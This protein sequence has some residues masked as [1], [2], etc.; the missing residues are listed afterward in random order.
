MG[1]YN[2]NDITI[3]WATDLSKLGLTGTDGSTHGG[4][5]M[6]DSTYNSNFYL[7]WQSVANKLNFCSNAINVTSST[8]PYISIGTNFS[9]IEKQYSTITVPTGH[10]YV[11]ANDFSSLKYYTTNINTTIDIV[12]AIIDPF[13]DDVIISG[14]YGRNY[15][16]TD[17]A[18]R[19]DAAGIYKSNLSTTLNGTTTTI[20]AFTRTINGSNNFGTAYGRLYHNSSDTSNKYFVEYYASQSSQPSYRRHN[21]TSYTDSTWHLH[22]VYNS[23][24]SQSTYNTIAFNPYFG[25][26]GSNNFILKK[27]SNGGHTPYL[28]VNSNL[29][30][31]NLIE[32]GGHTIQSIASNGQGVI[33]YKTILG[34][35]RA[36]V[37]IHKYSFVCLS[38]PNAT[39][40]NKIRVS[41]ENANGVNLSRINVNVGLFSSGGGYKK[42]DLLWSQRLGKF[43]TVLPKTETNAPSG[44]LEKSAA[45]STDGITW[46][47]Y[48]LSVENTKQPT[49]L[50]QTHDRF[51]LFLGNSSLPVNVSTNGIDYTQP[52]QSFSDTS[53]NNIHAHAFRPADD[54]T[55]NSLGLRRL[56]VAGTQDGSIRSAAKFYYSDNYSN[57]NV[58]T[59]TPSVAEGAIAGI[60]WSHNLNKFVA[61][62]QGDNYNNYTAK[63]WESV[64]GISWTRRSESPPA[65]QYAQTG[66]ME[67]GEYIVIY[68][69]DW[70]SAF[71]TKDLVTFTN[72]FSV[73]PH[74]YDKNFSSSYY[75]SAAG[76]YNHFY[77]LA[78]QMDSHTPNIQQ[79]SFGKLVGGYLGVTNTG[80]VP[81]AQS[82]NGYTGDYGSTGS[83]KPVYAD[84]L[85]V[86]G[87]GG[88]GSSHEA[89]DIDNKLA[90]GAGGGAGAYVSIQNYPIVRGNTYAIT[91]G[92][93]GTGHSGLFTSAVAEQGNNTNFHTFNAPGGG[94]G[95]NGRAYSSFSGAG[96]TYG[97][98]GSGGGGGALSDGG[99][100]SS[101][102]KQKRN[103]GGAG[104]GSSG[105]SLANLNGLWVNL[106]RS[107]GGGGAGGAGNSGISGGAV[108]TLRGTGGNG[109]K[110]LDG[111]NYAGGGGGAQNWGSLAS[112][113]DQTSGVI[114]G[115]GGLG[116]GGE[117]TTPTYSGGVIT[118]PAPTAGAANTGGGGG[119]GGGD[120]AG[121]NGGSGVVIIRFPNTS[122]GNM[123]NSANFT[124]THTVYPDGY[125]TYFKFTSG[126]GTITFL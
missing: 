86:G 46:T 33:A 45:F 118:F 35:V 71:T 16:G 32:I 40:I 44:T 95:G 116:G 15:A 5:S 56:V 69:S 64:D 104:S 36:Q 42:V 119:G 18:R 39:S 8:I 28:V 11:N 94:G 53:F 112:A 73:A 72:A 19:I 37:G 25:N 50:V 121:A 81:S 49:Y 29:G 83:V 103:S 22:N 24:S 91:V 88:G 84:I 80:S 97:I 14:G 92:T 70:F 2:T 20:N 79:K 117:G 125:Y 43:Y 12:D 124:G 66:I 99:I 63:I 90:C 113:N 105:N 38:Y 102:T 51:I 108:S 62:E 34:P 26:Q 67:V 77:P 9:P 52:S 57:F 122:G 109:L 76:H 55:T 48:Q 23:D 107:G 101:D 98:G 78:A 89:S 31:E 96:Q 114:G 68:S 111:N 54:G 3:R 7:V 61:V 21:G 115:Y 74:F 110:W 6:P 4:F 47:Y 13:S 27:A 87:G 106:Y 58:C 17:N 123:M 41:Q 126:S 1:L 93:G 85:I 60:I 82:S 59:M 65:N 100:V 120:K 30:N 10:I 75:G